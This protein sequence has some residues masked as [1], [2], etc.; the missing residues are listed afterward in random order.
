MSWRMLEYMARLACTH[1]LPMHNVV[2][3]VGQGAGVG[4]TGRHQLDGLANV[5]VLSWHYQVIRLWQIPAQELLALDRPA[6]LTLVGQTRLERPEVV[7]PTVVARLCRVPD[8]EM[9]GRLLTAFIALMPNEEMLAMTE[10]LLEDDGLLLDTPFLRRI[11]A[12][13]HTEGTL[14]TRRRDI[15][16]AL[17]LRFA[18]PTTLHHQLEQYLETLT[19]KGQLK[20]LFAA[21]IQ[22]ASLADFQAL[23]GNEP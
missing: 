15:L 5:A 23:L 18:L 4:D 12:E 7:L 10:R 8:T 2:L 19:D 21:A 22:S 17:A 16:E 20:R 1:R 13:G 14:S 11:R 3:Y 9:R 6:L